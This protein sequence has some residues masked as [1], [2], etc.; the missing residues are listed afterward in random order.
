MLLLINIRLI[1][2]SRIVVGSLERLVRLP[3]P[4]EALQS[5]CAGLASPRMS[6]P[7]AS[8]TRWSSVNERGCSGGKSM[9]MGCPHIQHVASDGS[10][11]RRRRSR[12]TR[13]FQAWFQAHGSVCLSR[14]GVMCGTPL[15]VPPV[16]WPHASCSAVADGAVAFGPGAEVGG[17]VGDAAGEVAGCAPAYFCCAFAVFPGVTSM[18]VALRRR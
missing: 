10:R 6:P 2:Q 1:H 16:S 12:W 5:R 3:S 9:L 8:G 4:R 15:F 14:R 7:R 17:E 18:R 11:S 13:F